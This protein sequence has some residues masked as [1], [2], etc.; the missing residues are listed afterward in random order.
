MSPRTRLLIV[1]AALA[2]ALFSVAYPL[3][4]IR[5]FRAQGPDELDAALN[6]I[7]IRPYLLAACLLLALPT[8][9][10]DW[11]AAARPRR[12]LAVA[13][14]TLALVL[15]AG[16]SRVNIFERMFHRIDVPEFEPAASARLDNG[17]MLLT[18]SVAG[19]AR[20]YPVRA[21]A[22]HHIV[23]DTV[24]GTPVVGTY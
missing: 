9:F 1:A 11:R 5:P 19:A 22:Y 21:L 17:E 8:A 7:R 16:L 24:A 20:A 10:L 14:L 3:Y 4:V 2:L 6:L 23:N 13:A 18:I 12:K 15:A